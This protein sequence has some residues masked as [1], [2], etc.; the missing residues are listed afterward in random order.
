MTGLDIVKNF[1]NL[2]YN[3]DPSS[4]SGNDSA[5]KLPIFSMVFVV[6]R[7][8]LARGQGDLSSVPALEYPALTSPIFKA[9]GHR[10]NE[11]QALTRI[12]PESSLRA[13]KPVWMT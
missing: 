4:P 7:G 2:R 8:H 11:S 10:E 12:T 1:S 9:P 3:V 6:L 13:E 5:L